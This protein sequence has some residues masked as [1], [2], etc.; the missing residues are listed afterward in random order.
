MGT[1]ITPNSAPNQEISNI[2]S[3]AGL[4]GS[5]GPGIQLGAATSATVGFYGT[6]PVV[7][8]AVGSVV[9]TTTTS[10]GSFTS[11]QANAI[12]TAVAAI[13]AALKVY[14]LSS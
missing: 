4:P 7:Q 12:S 6:T 9:A 13:Q 11:S 1:G 14:G 8:Q 3:E 2:P 10:T 5:P